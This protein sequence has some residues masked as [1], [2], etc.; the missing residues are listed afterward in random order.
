MLIRTPDEITAE[1]L[2]S[3]LGRD[4]LEI[5]S[6][7]EIGTGQM[8]QNHR[9]TFTADGGA[10]ETVVLKLASD[11]EDSRAAGVGLG[12]YEREINFYSKLAGDLPTGLAG[13]HLAEYDPAEGWFT[14][15]LDD[16]E[17]AVQ[18]DQ[19]KGCSPAEARLAI[20]A[21][22]AIHAPVIGD[23]GVGVSDWLNLDS[24]LTQDLHAAL[25]P[26][27]I[28]RYEGRL[29]GE[30]IAVA[31]RFVASHDAWIDD[32]RPPLGLVHGDFRLD[33]L[34]FGD[35]Q[36]TVV[37]WQTV[38]WGPAMRDISYFLG[39]SLTTED[40]RANEDELVRAYF[41][42]LVANGATNLEWETCWEE[43]RR[44]TFLGLLMVTMPA[45]VVER[46]DRGDEMFMA[47][48]ERV[49]Q[50]ILDLGSLD[51]LPDPQSGARPHLRPTVADEGR[52]DHTSEALWNESWY[53][54]AVSADGKVGVYVRLGRL[55]NQDRSNYVVCVCGPDRPTVMLADGDAP[56]PARDDDDQVVDG[57]GYA[58]QPDL[59]G[60]F[61]TISGDLRGWGG[62]LR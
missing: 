17:G 12:A 43:Y 54:D 56:L 44:Q 16:I 5:V 52:H 20:D 2:G 18:G 55:P 15:V 47:C 27:F 62:V 28:E 24:P 11:N 41:D 13:C 21:M 59:P 42:A 22:A 46:T 4:N 35:G 32:D 23:L 57:D 48:F 36:V 50:Q 14:L 58:G 34:L 61:A 30:H 26:G 6:T 25:L 7:G 37:D 19:I 1:W 39:N 40:R 10:E 3:A 33:N 53:A 31:E 8:S 51:L 60:A 49:A 29:R 45:M 9:V 38:G